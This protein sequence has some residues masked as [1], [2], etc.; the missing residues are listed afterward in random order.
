MLFIRDIGEALVSKVCERV[1]RELD[2]GIVVRDLS[3]DRKSVV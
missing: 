3:L 1:V 2:G